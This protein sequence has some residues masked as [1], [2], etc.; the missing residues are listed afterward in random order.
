MIGLGVVAAG[1]E[2]LRID[3]IA[4]GARRAQQQ[5]GNGQHA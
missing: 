4:I 1:D 5:C 3:V 2:R